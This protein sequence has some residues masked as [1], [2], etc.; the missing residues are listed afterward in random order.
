MFITVQKAVLTNTK[1]KRLALTILSVCLGVVSETKAV[2]AASFNVV[3]SG[4]DNPRRISFGT[5]GSLYVAESGK[6]GTGPVLVGPELN[7]LLSFGLTGAVTRVQNGEQKRVVSNLPSLALFPAGSTVPQNFGSTLSSVGPHDIGFDKSGNAYAILGFAS[8]ASQKATLGPNGADLGKLLSFN[9]NTDGS[10]TKNPNFSIDLLAYKNLYNPYLQGTFFGD[11]LN[12]PYDLE[13]QG[14][15]F[16]IADA[17]GNNFFSADLSG[18]VTL[19]SRF[20][21]RNINNAFVEPVPTSITVGADGAYY[22]SEFTGIPY[23]EKVA[24]IY[25][26][27]PG[28]KPEVYLDGFTQITGLDFDD[29]GNLY[30]LEYSVNSISDPTAKLAG[31]VIQ[32]SPDG[33]RKTLIGADEG[34]VAP[35]G[36]TVGP[37]GALYISNLTNTIGTGQVV[38][39]DP[40]ARAV[41]EPPF[42]LA[43]LVVAVLTIIGQRN[44][45]C[46]LQSKQIG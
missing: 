3:A 17:G 14:D 26:I 40:K 21:G 36:L 13:V 34:L 4:L 20:V 11:F 15:K 37:D 23:P 32:V 29:E 42:S 30:V 24:R 9:V 22:V 25:R 27:A 39:F 18:N 5:D 2:E 10:W 38:R 1:F 43:V 33:T 46:K 35:N 6:G 19:E 31:Q 41:P 16:V 28:G 7:V 44:Y 45:H 8:T 12:N